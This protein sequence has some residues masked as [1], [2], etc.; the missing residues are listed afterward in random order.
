MF[1]FKLSFPCILIVLA[2]TSVFQQYKIILPDTLKI[3]PQKVIE[4]DT[5]QYKFPVSDRGYE[6]F[7]TKQPAKEF[8][9]ESFYKAW[10]NWYVI[11]WNN[12]NRHRNN[13]RI[14]NTYIEYNS[15]TEYGL[16]VEY[17]LYNFFLYF[18]NLNNI[19]LLPRGR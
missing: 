11:E 15:N 9:S 7:L 1:F 5:I 18:E 8:Y 14:F 4:G 19:R 10:N 6:N 2:L 13:P 16:E 12:R 3:K 17:R